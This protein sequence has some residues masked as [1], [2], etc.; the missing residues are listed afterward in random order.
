MTFLKRLPKLLLNGLIGLN[1]G[2]RIGIA[3]PLPVKDIGGVPI[4]I[5]VLIA[6]VAY[7]IVKKHLG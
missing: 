7:C 1:N 3:R 4:G 5:P 6:I 2:V